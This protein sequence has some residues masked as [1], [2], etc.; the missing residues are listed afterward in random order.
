MKFP[1]LLSSLKPSTPTSL[2]TEIIA[3]ATL[4]AIGIPEVIGYS[5]IAKMPVLAGV[6]TLII[7][8]VLFV[9]FGSSKHLVVAADSATAAILAAGLAGV[10]VAGTSNYV[11]LAG[12]VAGMTGLILIVARIL[13]LGFIASF[14]SRTLLVGFLIGVGISVAV[15]QLPAMLGL[16]VK[17]SNT[18]VLLVDCATHLRAVSLPALVAS[19]LTLAIVLIGRQWPKIPFAGV[20]LVGAIIA[21]ETVLRSTSSL[22][23]VGSVTGGLPHLALPH[24]PRGDLGG[25]VALSL[26]LAL[27]ILAQSAAT[28]RAYAL[29]YDEPFDEERDLVG[30]GL[31]NLGAMVSGTYVV[32]GSPTKTEIVDGVGARSQRAALVTAAISVVALFTIAGPL[33]HLPVAVLAAVVVTIALRLVKLRDLTAIFAQRRDEGVV[34]ILTAASV[35]AFGVEIG[36]LVSVVVCLINHVRRGYDPRNYVMET[37]TEGNWVASSVEAGTPIRPGLFLYRFE[38][39]LYY[40]NVEKLTAEVIMLASKPGIREICIDASAIPDVDYSAGKELLSLAKDLGERGVSI[41]ITH[42]IDL[43]R[44]ELRRYGVLDLPTVSIEEGTREVIDRF[45]QSS[46]A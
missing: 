3:G 35:L 19:V 39:S 25:L 45:P 38:A 43:V 12:L 14:L 2:S 36:I 26:S 21:S 40:A 37:D 10:A 41:T 6:L 9:I 16:H 17:A 1:A 42:C 7:P 29:R 27:V 22:A 5:T 8:M 15:S 46:E 33:N 4:A 44:D 30:L 24:V 20:V 11:A 28:S 34:A 13:Q 31:A 18:F 32:N 23:F